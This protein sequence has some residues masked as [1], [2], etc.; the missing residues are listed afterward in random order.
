MS[1]LAVRDLHAYYGE[2]HVLQ[3]V[4]LDVPDG[5]AVSLVGRNGAGKTTL[6]RL[7]AGLLTPDSGASRLTGRAGYL[8]QD[9]G[10][11]LVCERVDDEVGLGGHKSTRALRD[12]GLVGFEHRHPRDLSSGERERVTLAAV[13]APDPDLLVLDEPTRGMDPER[14]EELAA[15]VRAQ[16]RRRATLVVTHD[17]VFAGDVADREI[18]LGTREEALV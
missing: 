8:P 12:L 16:A 3:G 14:K 7:A 1:A 4:S 10:R 11:Y 2:S 17:L 6:A 5:G 15:L 9:S 18:A 13:L